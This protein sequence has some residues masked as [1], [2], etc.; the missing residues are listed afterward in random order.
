MPDEGETVLGCC[1]LNGRHSG[2]YT[3]RA[4]VIHRK[5][6]AID[7]YGIKHERV[8]HW[9]PLPAAPQEVQGD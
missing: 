2:I 9:M 1:G 6:S 4:S 7:T 3:M 8:T 5:N